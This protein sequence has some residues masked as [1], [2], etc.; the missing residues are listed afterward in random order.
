METVTKGGKQKLPKIFK[1][2]KTYWHDHLLESSCGALSDGTISFSIQSF[3][4]EKCIFWIKKNKL[5]D[6]ASKLASA[7]C[8]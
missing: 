1:I 8:A 6:F 4:G 3:L 2:A 5:P 7:M